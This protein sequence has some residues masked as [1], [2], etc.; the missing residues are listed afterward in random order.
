MEVKPPLLL[1]LL[2]LLFVT[3]PYFSPRDGHTTNELQTLLHFTIVFK[4]QFSNESKHPVLYLLIH[5]YC[6]QIIRHTSTDQDINPKI[7]A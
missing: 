1:L 5:R 3:Q 4:L 7:L 2:L 6:Q